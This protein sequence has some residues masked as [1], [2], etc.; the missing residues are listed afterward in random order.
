MCRDIFQ[1]WDNFSYFT[2]KTEAISYSSW[3][4]VTYTGTKPWTASKG[5]A[6]SCNVLSQ[7]ISLVN[8]EQLRLRACP[9]L[10]IHEK[11]TV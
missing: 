1:Y 3:D 11:K 9:Y 2:Q 5:C 4:T 7:I 8:T 10:V 6:L